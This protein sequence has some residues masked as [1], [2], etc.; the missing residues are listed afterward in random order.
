M[1]NAGILIDKKLLNIENMNDVKYIEAIT[2]KDFKNNNFM[3]T[4]LTSL[5]EKINA[6]ARNRGK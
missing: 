3:F 2:E 5:R 4:V 6:P 1:D